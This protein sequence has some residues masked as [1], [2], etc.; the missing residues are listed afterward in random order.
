MEKEIIKKSK[1]RI[2]QLGEVF[3]PLFL[4]EKALQRLLLLKPTEI[5]DI[6]VDLQCGTGNL[7]IPVIKT[8]INQG[9]TPWQ[10]LSTTL[11]VDIMEDNVNE[12][13]QRLLQVAQVSQQ[14]YIDLLKTTIV[15]GN[16]L[17]QSTDELFSE[18]IK[19]Y[20]Q[21]S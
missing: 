4:S 10:A 12:C 8:K 18:Y 6:F 16:S 13:R 15:Q 2:K 21:G 20:K 14:K 9:L 5:N 19:K 7:L 11:G 3:T 1:E 17:K